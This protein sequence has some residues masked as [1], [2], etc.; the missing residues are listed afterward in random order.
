[1]DR[2]NQQKFNE[3]ITE[4][5]EMISAIEMC[6]VEHLTRDDSELMIKI[7]STILSHDK[8]RDDFTQFLNDEDAPDSVKTFMM[9]VNEFLAEEEKNEQ[10]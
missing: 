4:K 1:M 6:L 2:E 9:S 7:M 8:F 5:L 10:R 3:L